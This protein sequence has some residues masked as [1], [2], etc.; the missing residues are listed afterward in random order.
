MRNITKPPLET[1][2]VYRAAID[3]VGE[4]ALRSEL[5]SLATTVEA[6]DQI[7]EES[8][9]KSE[10]YLLNKKD[11]TI[12]LGSRRKKDPTKIIKF[13]EEVYYYGLWR[14]AAERYRLSIIN[15][16]PNGMCPLCEISD[17]RTLDHYLPKTVFHALCVSVANLIPCCRDCNTDKGS[18]VPTKYEEQTFHPYV[19]VPIS[20]I[21]LSAEVEETTPPSISYSVTSPPGWNEQAIA[22]I[23]HTFNSLQ[24]AGRYR[25]HASTL[26]SEY[27]YHL[28]REYGRGGTHSV[29]ERAS[30]RL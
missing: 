12:S 24:L 19:D 25:V 15:N 29:R 23:H 6:A 18:R 4:P 20:D 22:R 7:F 17:A 9:R 28:S 5:L 1:L 16:A 13:H 27:S 21:W 26:I 2:N 11:F 10:I 14:E 8:L 3:G 30:R